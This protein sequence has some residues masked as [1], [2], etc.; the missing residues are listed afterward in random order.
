MELKDLWRTSHRLSSLMHGQPLNWIASVAR[1]CLFLT[2][3]MSFQG[4]HF[5]L[6]VSLIFPSKKFH[7]IFLTIPLNL[8]QFSSCQDCLDISKSLQQLSFH[9]TLGCLVMF[10][11]LE[12]LCYILSILSAN[13]WTM[14]SRVSTLDRVDKIF[15]EA[16]F[17]FTVLG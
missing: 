17:L 15:G 2:Q 1:R 5:L 14:I 16:S 10:T 8:F 11:I 4:L 7:F 6:V 3:F 9:H 12:C 13:D